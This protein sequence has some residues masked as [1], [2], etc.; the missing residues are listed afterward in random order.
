MSQLVFKDLDKIISSGMNRQA[1]YQFVVIC[2]LSKQR[3][4]TANKH[5][6]CE[7]LQKANKSAKKDC[8]HY[9]N[10]PVWNVLKNKGIIK[11]EGLQIT[12][13]LDLTLSQRE[14][15]SAKCQEVI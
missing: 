7:V 2:H 13:N 6:L 1:N 3:G 9:M 10:C 5:D 8:K 11:I 15:L 4:L 14:K 12:L